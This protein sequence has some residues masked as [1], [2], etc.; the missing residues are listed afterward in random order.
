MRICPIC[1]SKPRKALHHQ[2]FEVPEN[3]SLPN[4]YDVVSCSKCGFV[5]ADVDATQED[6]S[7]YYKEISKY[8]VP[9]AT[10]NWNKS[11]IEPIVGN[12]PKDASIL[13]IGCATGQLLLRLYEAGYHDLTGLD[14]SEKCLEEV[15]RLEFKTIH[16]DFLT[17]PFKE[18]YDCVILS[19]VLE[20]VYDLQ[21]AVKAIDGLLRKGGI[22]YVEVPDASRYEDYFIA[23]FH[24]FDHEHINHFDEHSLNRPFRDAG[25][26]IEDNGHKKSYVSN[27]T[28]PSVYGVYGKTQSFAETGIKDY[29]GKSYQNDSWPR[30]DE[31]AKSQEEVVV[32]PVGAYTMRLLKN[33]SLGKCN[34]KFFVDNDRK[35]WGQMIMGRTVF[36][37]TKLK[38]TSCPIIVCSALHSDEIVDE[39]KKVGLKNEIVRR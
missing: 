29:I 32:W 27:K 4:E 11:N 10:T 8:G 20:H 19:H 35:K 18:K 21:A 13:D 31:L 7:S 3:F 30:V 36:P 22:L 28:Y 25:F 12:L 39:I 16:G 37:P 15:S 34:I 2:S 9:Q 38:D 33:T 24:Y 17:H 6:Y 23:P 1:Q 5:F 14:L 26:I